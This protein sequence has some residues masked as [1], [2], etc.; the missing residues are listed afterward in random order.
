LIDRRALVVTALCLVAWRLLYQLPVPDVTH[1]VITNRVELYSGA[2]FFAAIGPN[3]L[4]LGSLSLG[5][6]GIGPYVEALV[7]TALVAV[8][9][10]RV[11][12]MVR[13]PAGWLRVQRWTRALAIAL[14]LGQAYGFTVL[15]QNTNPAALGQLDWSA[16]LLVCL[17]LVGGTALMIFLADTL[18]EFGLGFGYGAVFFF[19]LG[20]VGSEFHRIAGYL[21]TTP[22]VEALYRPLALWAAFTIGVTV[23]TVALLLAVRRIPVGE[24]DGSKRQGVLEIR[25]IT[26]GV[27]RPPQFAFA[28]L[29]LPTI[30]A[31]Y[32][33]DTSVYNARWFLANWSPYGPS[34]WL[35][36]VY[37]VAE[38]ALIVFFAL[39]ITAWDFAV[40]PAPRYTA[41]HVNRLAIA[42]AVAL[43][44]LVV[45]APVADHFV[46][47]AAGTVISM[48]GATVVLVV[49]TVLL[50][51]RALEGHRGQVPLTASPAGLV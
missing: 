36:A 37:V 48:S 16:R 46:T 21:A 41:G 35:D 32:S 20:D 3:S 51:V 9:S 47:R 11:R 8:L 24:G 28:V 45:G 19:A 43:A 44:L 12:D 7:I 18:D 13:D 4:P 49:A 27:L 1:L 39:A 5:A 38:A 22:S 17:A 15:F 14:A 23:A 29:F 34:F 42:G 50:T 2:G 10:R 33:V 30:V 6:E 25:L 40:V 26:S 31:N